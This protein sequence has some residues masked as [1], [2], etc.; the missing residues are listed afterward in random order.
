[1][2]DFLLVTRMTDRYN[3]R[4]H[5]AEDVGPSRNIV[6]I[7]CASFKGTLSSRQAGDAIARGMRRAGVDAVVVALAD[8]GEGLVEALVS[9]VPGAYYVDTV[10]RGPLLDAVTAQFGI[11]G[12]P[13]DATA[14]IE[15]AESSG[16]SLVPEGKRDPKITTTLGVGDQIRGALDLPGVHVTRLLIGIGGSA[17]NDGG[18]GM[19]RALGARFLDAAGDD[20]AHGGA[21]LERLARIDMSGFDGRMTR[22][23]ITVACDVNNPLCGPQGASVVYGP[24]KGATAGDVALLD[25]ALEHYAAIVERDLGKS[26]RDVPGAGAAG[27]LGAG[28]LAFCN[29]RLVSG[30]DVL[31]DAIAFDGWLDDANIVITGEGRLDGQTLMGKAP[32]GVARRAARKNVFCIAIGGSVD[33]AVKTELLAHFGR[34]ES[35]GEFAGSVERAMADA[36]AVLEELAF[37]RAGEWIGA[38]AG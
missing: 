8:G 9:Q 16:L 37:A 13:D 18:A 4:R 26:I 29:A 30:I 22:I 38:A 15:M 5:G 12:P 33:E 14:V 24:Q 34:I 11:M 31:L 32:L 21:A 6:V 7:A 35:L 17:T 1:M 10:V 2:H 20:L 25:T 3:R 27:G 19:A 28:L 36:A 23:P